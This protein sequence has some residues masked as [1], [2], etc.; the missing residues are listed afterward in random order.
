L[1]N[2]VP[3]DDKLL[4]NCQKKLMIHDKI[5]DANSEGRGALSNFSEGVLLMM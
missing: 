1:I 5:G 3:N 2:Q 4:D